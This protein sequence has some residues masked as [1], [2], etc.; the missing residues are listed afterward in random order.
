MKAFKRLYTGDPKTDPKKKSSGYKSVLLASV[1]SSKANSI[2]PEILNQLESII[3]GGNIMSRKDDLKKHLGV[4]V[5][6]YG[7]DTS[8]LADGVVDYKTKEEDL[9][10]FQQQAERAKLSA[11]LTALG[12]AQGGTINIENGDPKKKQESTGYARL[13]ARIARMNEDQSDQIPQGPRAGLLDKAGR[14]I[15]QR[16]YESSNNP[17]ADSGYA[18][19]YYG[20]SEAAMSDAIRDGVIEPGA[21]VTDPEVNEKVRDYMLD[22]IAKKEWISNPPQP[23]SELNRLSR[24]YGSYNFGPTKYLRQ[25][26]KA[27]AAG[28]DIYSDNPLDYLEFTDP[29]GEYDGYFFP[30]ETRDYASVVSG[31]IE[32]DRSRIP[33]EIFEYLY[34]QTSKPQ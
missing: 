16:W 27:K 6:N 5:D 34:D 8:K 30:K 17:N 19:G 11:G 14:K 12:Y 21:D 20:I 26:E 15:V 2:P 10:W 7:L 4:L 28:A 23:I 33:S 29:S 31:V 22:S 25:L 1:D 9:N 24:I 32:A 13:D 18:K 3:D